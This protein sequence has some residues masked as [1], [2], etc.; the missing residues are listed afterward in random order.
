MG[1]FEGINRAYATGEV[2]KTPQELQRE[3]DEK[4]KKFLAQGWQGGESQSTRA[5]QG[6]K[7][8]LDHL[9]NGRNRKIKEV[10]RII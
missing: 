3:L 10:S 9:D 8:K 2:P 1:K 6:T 5:Y 4:M 7:K